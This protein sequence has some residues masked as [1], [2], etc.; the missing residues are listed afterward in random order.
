MK[1]MQ[2]D[3]FEE[4]FV[5]FVDENDETHNIPKTAF[6]FELHEGD[7][8]ALDMKDGELLCAE[9][10]KEETEAARRRTQALMEKLKKRSR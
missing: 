3:R 9:F 1:K 5:V 7:I 8:L 10:L 2:I 6:P 4:S